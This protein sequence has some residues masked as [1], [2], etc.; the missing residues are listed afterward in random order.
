MLPIGDCIIFHLPLRGEVARRSRAGGGLRDSDNHLNNTL[1]VFH[2]IA[3]P[4]TKNTITATVEKCCA[5]CMVFHDS[6]VSVLRIIELD[7][8]A[9]SDDTRNPE[10]SDRRS[11]PSK[12]HPKGLQ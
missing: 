11:L 7:N 2:H 5:L 1:A 8:E 12:M 10:S 9:W 4:E 6:I 3:V